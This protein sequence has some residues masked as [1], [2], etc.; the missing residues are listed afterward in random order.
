M[1]GEALESGNRAV[2]AGGK[3]MTFEKV[4]TSVGVSGFASQLQAVTELGNAP[5]GSE[6]QP[7]LDSRV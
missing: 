2:V 7:A 6:N 4:V 1:A 5:V 3:R